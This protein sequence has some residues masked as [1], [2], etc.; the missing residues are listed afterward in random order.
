MEPPVRERLLEAA[1]IEL[2]RKGREGMSVA[3]LL[4]AAG[5]SEAD[6][7]S[8]YGDLDACLDDAYEQL[9]TR[10]EVAAQRG[11]DGGDLLLSDGV[12]WPVR[13]RGGL[14]A[15]L[16][17]L[18]DEPE[19]A[20]TLTRSYPS[21][22][23]AQMARYQR[24]VESFAPPLRAG[25]EMTGADQELPDEV[26]LLAV[27]AAEAILVDEVRAGRAGELATMGPEILFSLLVPFVGSAAAAEE[28]ERARASR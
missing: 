22:G 3:G 1:L 28:M 8:S 18:A 11:C 24:F 26:E 20:R 10:L 12:A 2:D 6:F 19:L 14:E 4:A 5:V 13:V 16:A 23:P 21:L 17:E 9:T 27:G 25:W 7:A 15:L